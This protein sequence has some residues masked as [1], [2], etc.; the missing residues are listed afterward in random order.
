MQVLIEIDERAIWGLIPDVYSVKEL[1][2]DAR[3]H[4]C[5][6]AATFWLSRSSQS[7]TGQDPAVTGLDLHPLYA[8]VTDV[9]ALEIQAAVNE[10]VLDGPANVVPVPL[11]LPWLVLLAVMLGLAPAMLRRKLAPN[12]R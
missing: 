3:T 7:L 5:A 6:G 11:P 12:S 9:Q 8:A 4:E 2:R 10:V 1:Y